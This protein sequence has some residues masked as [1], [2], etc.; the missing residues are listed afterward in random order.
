MKIINLPQTKTRARIVVATILMAIFLSACNRGL[1][2]KKNLIEYGPDERN[3]Q[4]ETDQVHKRT[5]QL[6]QLII[7]AD[8]ALAAK[9]FDRAET[10]YKAI[11]DIDVNQLRAQEG[12][13]RV[14]SQRQHQTWLTL[15]KPMVG[16]SGE[17]DERAKMLLSKILIEDPFNIEARSLY[18]A[19]LA[20]EEAKR[21]ESLKVRL[22]YSSPV[23][24]EFR[25]TDF[26]A[27]IEALAKGTGINFTLDSEV[28]SNLRASIFVK[29]VSI[30]D[31]LDMLVQSNNLRKKVLTTNTVL[32]YPDKATKVR[33][34]QDLIIRSFYL[35]YADPETVAG[36]LR[37]ML[38]IKQI[39]TDDRLP[40]ILI[41]DVPEVISMAAKLIASQDVPEPEVMLE[42]DII[43][44][45][46]TIDEDL[47]FQW[48]TQLS[49]LS[50]QAGLT[51]EALRNTDSS[52]IGVSPNPFIIFDG[53]DEEV[54]LLANP[55]IRV[56]SG[57]NA[58]IHIG[59]RVPI[60]TS[61]VASTGTIS[62]NVQYIDVGL[63]LEVEPKVNLG[64]DVNI[65]LHLEVSTT[66]SSIRT[67]SGSVVFEIGTR[68]TSTQL[69]LQDGETQ[70]LAGL[71]NDTDRKNISKIPWLGDIPGFGR[72]FSTHGDEKIKTELVLMITPRIIRQSRTRAAALT[73]YWVGSEA[74]IGR[75]ITQPR[76]LD[77]I[78]QSLKAGQ[79]TE[80]VRS[81]Q[82]YSQPSEAPAGL[83][84]MLPP[85]LSSEF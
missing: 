71:I 41:K 57:D 48:P 11:L 70:V 44:I 62:E 82:E 26:K 55:R 29:N 73:E 24:L 22:K 19:I 15:A 10:A 36:L 56:K 79:A 49:V 75:S 27:I 16:S 6:K 54:A 18:Q 17:G 84:I 47:G 12:L 52:T 76:R 43:E 72:L 1:T 37:S 3:P 64:G 53:K 30:E 58:K 74:Q 9:D 81:E 80:T 34:Y 60:I 40:T 67:N 20:A 63:K 25:D 46:R 13:R 28:Q 42:M 21:V 50:G 66:G 65:K 61:N 45:R 39:A 23:S 68:S 69:R 5:A 14:S 7:D 77:N 51:L 78:S 35:E 31:A 4:E 32:I 33:Q 59:D 38:G 85:G 2:A 83:N 8:Q